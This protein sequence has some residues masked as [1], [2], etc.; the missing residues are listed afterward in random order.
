MAAVT[1]RPATGGLMPFRFPAFQRD[2]LDSGLS[3]LTCNLPGRELLAVRLVLEAG[4]TNEPS[5]SAGLAALTARALLEGTTQRD[6]AAFGEALERIGASLDA[7][8]DWDVMRVSATVPAV[9]LESL[10]ELLGETLA[11]PLFPA[12]ALER[13]RDERL[14]QIE[15]DRSNPEARARQELMEAIYT[16]DST[17][18]RPLAGTA[19]TVSSIDARAVSSYY[20]RFGTLSNATMVIAGDLPGAG[21]LDVVAKHLRAANVKP[22]ER[23]TA[24][25]EDALQANKIVVVHRPGAAQSALAIGHLGLSR[26]TTAYA[27][28]RLMAQ[29]LCGGGMLTTR[30]MFK[31]R[32][33]KGYTYGAYGGFDFRRS[34]GPFATDALV[35][36]G[37]TAAA[38][39]DMHA[40][41]S[42]M[43]ERGVEQGELDDARNFLLGSWPVRYQTPAAIADGIAEIAVHD[44]G[45]DHMD[46][47][48]VD[49]LRQDVDA[50][51]AA[52]REYLHPQRCAIVVVGDGDMVTED[53]EATGLGRLR[54][55]DGS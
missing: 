36:T 7:G 14:N 27:P 11:E 44:L 16:S 32:E 19:E 6:A 18:H 13:M 53:L 46:A 38:V 28:L 30:F 2:R 39:V 17:Y 45:D 41:I 31:L 42:K 33:E 29:A 5:A 25:V 20:S 22:A 9:H 15:L 23:P 4:A 47:L 37:V 49:M 26:A 55:V 52:A 48:H 8:V 54:I 34:A 50:V 3:V 21:T 10:L 43:Q 51:N 12:D 24:A 40:E 35:E 1:T